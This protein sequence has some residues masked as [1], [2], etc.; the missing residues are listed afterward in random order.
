[1]RL[2]PVI[3]KS[4]IT[5]P[6]RISDLTSSAMPDLHAT[7]FPENLVAR[8]ARVVPAT[9]VAFLEGPAADAQGRIFFT[10]IWNNR[11][12]C[13]DTRTKSTT[14]WRAAS[15]RA[16]GLLFDARHRLIVCEGNEFGGGGGRR[17]TRTDMTTGAVEVLTDRFEGSRYNSP[18]DVAA[19][20]NGQIFFTDPCYDDRASMELS[21]D[22]IYRIDLDGRVTRILTQPAIQRPNGIAL[23]PDEQ[24]LYVVDSCPVAGGN[25]KIWAFDLSSDGSPS[26]QRLV[27]D[28]APGRGGDGMAVDT[29][30][31]LYI[32]AGIFNPRTPHET[33]DVPPGVY[34]IT[35]AGPLLGRIP[36][37]EDVI[38]NVTFGGE[39]L[40]TL[41]VTA[42]RTLYSIEV[43]TPGWVV[44]RSATAK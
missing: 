44:H 24:T 4:S 27:F 34:L 7:P 32:A 38:T 10:D 2:S 31:N 16:N 41:Y 22:S 12:L 36:I 33:A 26:A 42:G 28:F 23:S 29:L 15:G 11:I 35:P 43:T 5:D 19:R 20:T 18:N 30:G 40:R 17:V 39:D 3:R 37:P 14:V 1:M 6:T 21:H 25:R 13:L 9:A 8:G